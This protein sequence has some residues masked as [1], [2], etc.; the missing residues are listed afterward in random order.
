MSKGW[1]SKKRCLPHTSRSRSATAAA[2]RTLLCK[3]IRLFG[4]ETTLHGVRYIVSP[5][6]WLAEKWVL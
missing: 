4:E 5:K 3:Q 6:S 2:C 1:R